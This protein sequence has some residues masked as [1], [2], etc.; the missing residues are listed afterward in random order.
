MKG[1]RA[2]AALRRR[3]VGPSGRI[4]VIGIGNAF[5]GDDG[6]GLAVA[7]AARALLPAAVE[8]VELDGEPAR[9]VEAWD[10][11][12]AAFVVDAVRSGASVG[13]LH[14]LDAIE[15]AL[16]RWAP[17]G[18]SHA[19]GAAEAVGLGRALDRLPAHLV[20]YGVEGATF[21][22]GASLT[23][24]V[25]A[26]VPVAASLLAAEAGAL[27]AGAAERGER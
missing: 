5:R 3:R 18:G 12:A 13:S 6:A 16:P 21:D 15:E 7:R 25:A 14:R 11:A 26:A 2:R 4:V 19:L 10:G 20:V 22:E 8:V 1:D 9:L 23:P 24:E 27:L 17:S